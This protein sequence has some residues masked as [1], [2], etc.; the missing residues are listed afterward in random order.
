M[1]LE[2]IK[3]RAENVVPLVKDN[4][5]QWG[6][7]A[8]DTILQLVEALKIKTKEYWDF[9]DERHKESMEYASRCDNYKIEIE[10]LTAANK[11]M[12]YFLQGH[13]EFI[14]V[15]QV[16]SEVDEAIK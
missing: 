8:A 2:E 12:L 15:T 7:W 10:K 5:K 11:I 6:V 9:V 16:L 3:Q 1:N 4:P 14:A 13:K